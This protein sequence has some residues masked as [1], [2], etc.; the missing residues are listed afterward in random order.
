MPLAG[1]TLKARDG[2]G[3]EGGERRGGAPG[4]RGDA[5]LHDARRRQGRS[6]SVSASAVGGPVHSWATVG[7]GSGD[8]GALPRGARRGGP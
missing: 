4:R 6:Q 1:L 5:D 8:N 2:E 7:R 3:L